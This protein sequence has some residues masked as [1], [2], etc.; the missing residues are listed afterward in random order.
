MT[1]SSGLPSAETKSPF[2]VTE[3]ALIFVPG[4]AVAAMMHFV[5]PLA[6]M[7]LLVAASNAVLLSWVLPSSSKVWAATLSLHL[8]QI[9]FFGLSVHHSSYT[10]GRIDIACIAVCLLWLCLKPGPSASF[11]L[12]TLN[13]VGVACGL[14]IITMNPLDPDL[15]KGVA[16]I[17]VLRTLS[18][19]Y[20]WTN[21]QAYLRLKPAPEAAAG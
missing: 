13:I 5:G 20:L 2:R 4:L 10:G 3:L 19:L 9:L 6:P 8:L 1:T 11:A 18:L 15:V 16:W 7:S 12:A 17:S 14:Y 21:Y